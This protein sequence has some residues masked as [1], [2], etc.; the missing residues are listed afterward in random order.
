MKKTILII[1]ILVVS[2]ISL[3]TEQFNSLNI[4]DD[5][6]FIVFPLLDT[7]TDGDGLTDF[8][9]LYVFGTDPYDNDTDDDGLLDGDE[10]YIYGSDPTDNDT[11]ED[12][13]LAGC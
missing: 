2:S 6:S 1:S 10:V 11:D 9:E 3:A 7:D 4:T 8:E 13:L 12:G 5:I